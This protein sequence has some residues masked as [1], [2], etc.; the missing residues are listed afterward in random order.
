MNFF[1]QFYFLVVG[2]ICI[3]FFTI[4]NDALND[5]IENFVKFISHLFSPKVSRNE[6]KHNAP[7]MVLSPNLSLSFT[8]SPYC[9]STLLLLLSLFLSP[10]LLSLSFSLGISNSYLKNGLGIQTQQHCVQES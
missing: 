7:Q 10:Y 1:S 8:F 5:K 9:L 6:Q 4:A 3:Y 2:A